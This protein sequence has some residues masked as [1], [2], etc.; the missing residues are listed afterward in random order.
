MENKNEDVA[1][2]L[3]WDNPYA[4]TI[5]HMG[6]AKVKN[7]VV[8]GVWRRYCSKSEKEIAK[9]LIELEKYDLSLWISFGAID[10]YDAMQVIHDGIRLLL[11]ETEKRISSGDIGILI[12]TERKWMIANELTDSDIK[13]VMSDLDRD[14]DR[15]QHSISNKI[16]YSFSP[17][18]YRKELSNPLLPL[19]IRAIYK[20]LAA[21]N[22]A[23]DQ[24]IRG[25]GILAFKHIMTAFVHNDMAMMTN[26]ME[27]IAASAIQFIPEHN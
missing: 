26:V 25:N 22:K 18:N 14:L 3:S 16:F 2:L 13:Q 7:D 5:R 19:H 1:R 15:F 11:K 17:Q 27:S 10:R 23:F 6:L 4:N 21:A 12:P 20:A 9:D 8:D 24:N